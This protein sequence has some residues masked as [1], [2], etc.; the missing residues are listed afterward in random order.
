MPDLLTPSGT[1]GTL[2]EHYLEG[3]FRAGRLIAVGS[4]LTLPLEPKVNA[5]S[6]VHYEFGAEAQSWPSSG[7]GLRTEQA[8]C[9]WLQTATLNVALGSHELEVPFTDTQSRRV[10]GLKSY[11]DL[12]VEQ[13]FI[14]GTVYRATWQMW[15][16]MSA[17]LNGVLEVPDACPGPDGDILL[18]WDRASEHFELEVGED[19]RA[20]FFYVDR[21]RKTSWELTTGPDEP[22]DEAVAR[23]LSFFKKQVSVS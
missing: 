9:S 13:R 18:T 5:G 20:T 21:K 10:Q 19:S 4:I 11:L 23:V 3:L 22:I 15:N 17:R 6:L 1:S 8:V 12:C 14:S 2:P 7:I 16:K